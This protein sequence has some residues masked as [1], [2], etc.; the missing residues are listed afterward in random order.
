M[1]I[2]SGV[3]NEHMKTHKGVPISVFLAAS[4][5]FG[6]GGGQRGVYRIGGGYRSVA[7]ATATTARGQCYGRR[8]GHRPEWFH[9]TDGPVLNQTPH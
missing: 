5:A 2:V 9:R 8:Y 1:E 4:K 7:I 3:A 6:I